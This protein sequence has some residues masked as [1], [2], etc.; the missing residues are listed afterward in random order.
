MGKSLDLEFYA[1]FDK[2][3]SPLFNSGKNTVKV[4]D[5]I[6][7][8]YLKNYNVKKQYIPLPHLRS[9]MSM[10]TLSLVLTGVLVVWFGLPYL[11]KRW[12]IVCL[13]K[14]CRK[15]KVIV[16]TYDDGPS[17]VLTPILLNVLASNDTHANFFMIGRKIE[18]FPSLVNDVASKGHSIGSHSFNHFHAW[19][20][21]PLDVSSDIQA[22]FQICKS[23]SSSYLFRPPFGKITLATLL[24]T[25][26]AHEKL[27]WWTIDSTDTWTNPLPIEN[28]IDRVRKEGGGVILMHDHDRSDAN[29]HEYVIDLTLRLIQ[30]AHDEGY[31]IL[32]FQDL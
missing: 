6:K 1:F 18:S 11:L 31:N 21:N 13:R 25:W 15:S 9:E 20:K 28:T 29:K 3:S 7:L 26:I 14:Q 27:A 23:I 24:Q 16:L 30:F 4:T 22:G 8:I 19:K 32:T 10:L 2:K 12:Q 17:E 5:D